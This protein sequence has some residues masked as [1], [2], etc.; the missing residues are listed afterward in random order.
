LLDFPFFFLSFFRALYTHPIRVPCSRTVRPFP[1]GVGDAGLTDAIC[2]EGGKEKTATR[3][4]FVSRTKQRR[5]KL[6]KKGEGGVIIITKS[7]E[8]R[9]ENNRTHAESFR[10]SLS[11]S[12]CVWS[13]RKVIKIIIHD[14]EALSLL[15]IPYS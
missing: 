3:N 1:A 5:G 2:L 13:Q 9:R 6:T 14:G 12:M 4:F 10:Q 15:Y 11:C 8:Q 7:I